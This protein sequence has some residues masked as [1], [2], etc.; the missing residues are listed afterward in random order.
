MLFLFPKIITNLKSL[1]KLQISGA[2]S[3]GSSSKLKSLYFFYILGL[4]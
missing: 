1:K 2:E 4:F 3:I